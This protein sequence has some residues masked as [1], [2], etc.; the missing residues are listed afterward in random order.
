MSFTSNSEFDFQTR[1]QITNEVPLYDPYKGIHSA[2]KNSVWKWFIGWQDIIYDVSMATASDDE[3]PIKLVNGVESETYGPKSEITWNGDTSSYD[4]TYPEYRRMELNGNFIAEFDLLMHEYYRYLDTLYP[5][6][7]DQRKLLTETE[8]NDMILN[9]AEMIDYTPNIKFLTNVTSALDTSLTAD[10]LEAESAKLKIRDLLSNSFRRKFYGSK[11]GYRMYTGQIMNFCSVYPLGTYIPVQPATKEKVYSSTGLYKDNTGRFNYKLPSTTGGYRKINKLSPLLHRKF[12][13]IDWTGKSAKYTATTVDKNLFSGGALPCYDYNVFE[14]PNALDTASVVED[15]SVGSFFENTLDKKGTTYVTEKTEVAEKYTEFKYDGAAGLLTSSE[16]SGTNHVRSLA[17]SKRNAIRYAK[18][19]IMNSYD[20]IIAALSNDDAKS[21]ADGYPYQGSTKINYQNGS[22]NFLLNFFERLTTA[23]KNSIEHINYFIGNPFNTGT[24]L[25]KPSEA[26]LMYPE[27]DEVSFTYANGMATGITTG[28]AEKIIADKAVVKVGQFISTQKISETVSTDL[29]SVFEVMGLTKGIIS[30]NSDKFTTTVKDSLYGY[31]I[32]DPENDALYGMLVLLDDGNYV[33]LRG[34]VSISHSVNSSGYE[35]PTGGTFYI[36]SIPSTLD[37]SLLRVIYGT[38][39]TDLLEKKN[40]YENVLVA[41]DSSASDK[42]TAQANID[43]I[44]AAVAVLTENRSKVANLST[45]TLSDGTTYDYEGSHLYKGC[46]IAKFYKIEANYTL[47]S[48]YWHEMVTYRSGLITDINLGCVSIFPIIREGQLAYDS[49][50]QNLSCAENAQYTIQADGS[51]VKINLANANASVRTIAGTTGIFEVKPSIIPSTVSG[52]FSG[53]STGDNCSAYVAVKK[54]IEIETTVKDDEDTLDYLT[55]DSDVAKLAAQT[56]NVG[57][58]VSGTSIPSDTY[59]TE[60]DDEYIRISKEATRKGTFVLTYDVALNCSPVDTGENFNIYKENLQDSSLYDTINPFAHGIYPSSPYPNVSKAYID[61]LSDISLFEPFADTFFNVKKTLHK[62]QLNYDTLTHA[63]TGATITNVANNALVPATVKFEGDIF[64]EI[65]LDKLLSVANR[66]GTTPTLCNIE[67]LNY[68]EDAIDDISRGTDRVNVGAQ[69]NLMTDTTG[70][71]TLISGQ[72]YTDPNVKS[73]FATFNWAEDSVPAYAQIGQG[74]AGRRSWFKA[75]DDIVYPDL[76]GSTFYDDHIENLDTALNDLTTNGGVLSKRSVW[77]DKGASSGTS[78]TSELD[79]YSKVEDLLFE[80]P[81][82]EY[83]TQL[84]YTGHGDSTNAI[85]TIQ[86]AFYK[87][88][89]KNITALLSKSDSDALVLVSDS[90]EDLDILENISTSTVAK[91]TDATGFSSADNLADFTFVAEW[92][93]TL[94]NNSIVYPTVTDAVKKAYE[95]G[96]IP[97]YTIDKGSSFTDD[98]NVTTTFENSSIL[99]YGINQ[100]TKD[101]EW[102]NRVFKVGCGAFESAFVGLGATAYR[103]KITLNNISIKMGDIWYAVSSD[104]TIASFTDLQNAFITTYEEISSKTALATGNALRMNHLYLIYC[105][106]PK[107]TM[108]EDLQLF[109]SG[110]VVGMYFDTASKK[111][112]LFGVNTDTRFASTI[113]LLVPDNMDTTEFREVIGRLSSSVNYPYTVP[114]IIDKTTSSFTLPRN[115]I[116]EGSANFKF[117]VDP[118]FISIGNR[119]TE[120]DGV[121]TKGTDEVHFDITASAIFY[122]SDLDEFY[123]KSYEYT[124]NSLTEKWEKA[125]DTQEMFAIKFADQE[126]YKNL[127]YMY[128]TYQLKKSQISGSSDIVLTPVLTLIDGLKFKAGI[129]STDDKILSVAPVKMRSFYAS[130]YENIAFNSHGE[131]TGALRSITEDGKT[132]V[133]S[134]TPSSSTGGTAANKIALASAISKIYPMNEISDGVYEVVSDSTVALKDTAFEA[135]TIVSITAG[136]Q[137][138]G[139]TAS[140]EN[141]TL[142]NK[143]FRNA[144]VFSATVDR[145]TPNALIP[146]GDDSYFIAAASKLSLRDTVLSALSLTMSDSTKRTITM[147]D[148]NGSALSIKP[149]KVRYYNNALVAVCNNGIIYYNSNI[150]LLETKDTVNLSQYNVALKGTAD[151]EDAYFDSSD[152]TWYVVFAYTDS[153]YEGIRAIFKTSDFLVWQEAFMTTEA[154]LGTYTLPDGVETDDYAPYPYI[155][156]T[157]DSNAMAFAANKDGTA[158]FAIGDTLFVKAKTEKNNETA[159]TEEKYWKKGAIPK[160]LDTTKVSLKSLGDETVIYS[161]ASNLYTATIAKLASNIASVGTSDARYT[162]W[163]AMKANWPA[164]VAFVAGQ[165]VYTIKNGA[166]TL[167]TAAMNPTNI[168]GL[169]GT[170]CGNITPNVNTNYTATA[171]SD[172][173]YNYFD[174]YCDYMADYLMYFC[175]SNFSHDVLTDSIKKV[176]FL[177]GGIMFQLTN[178]DFISIQENKLCSKAKIEDANNWNSSVFSTDVSF[179]SKA[180]STETLNTYF[181]LS[182]AIS[183]ISLGDTV[184]KMA[185]SFKIN[186]IETN[187]SGMIVLGGYFYTKAEITA[188]VA[189]TSETTFSYKYNGTTHTP[190][191]LVSLDNGATFNVASLD[192]AIANEKVSTIEFDGTDWKAYLV[193]ET[194]GVYPSVF[195]PNVDTD[196]SML[197]WVL[198]AESDVVVA[199]REI[200]ETANGKIATLSGSSTI[201]SY[202]PVAL[203]VSSG[204]YVTGASGTK[205]TL[206]DNIVDKGTGLVNVLFS[207]RTAKQISKPEDFIDSASVDLFVDDTYQFKVTTIYETG[208]K[209]D[210]DRAFL[211]RET[212]PTKLLPSYEGGYPSIREDS[213]RDFYKYD[214]SVDSDGNATYSAKNLTNSSG[215]NVLLCD[216]NGNIVVDP[217]ATIS[218]MRLYDI[219]K[220]GLDFSYVENAAKEPAYNT[221]AEAQTAGAFALDATLTAVLKL[222]TLSISSLCK[223]TTSPN[224][225]VYSEATLFETFKTYLYPYSAVDACATEIATREGITIDSSTKATRFISKT[226][227]SID[228]V[229]DA[230]NK[231]YPFMRDVLINT[232]M[233][234]PYFYND[235]PKKITA[236]LLVYDAKDSSIVSEPSGLSGM[237][238]HD[239][240]YGGYNTNTDSNWQESLPWEVDSAAFEGSILHN[241]LGSK[242]FLCT[243]LGKK[244]LSKKGVNEVSIGNSLTIEQADMYATKQ[245]ISLTHD[246][247]SDAIN[248]YNLADNKATLLSSNSYSMIS[249]DS[250][251]IAT[252]DSL[253]RGAGTLSMIHDNATVDPSEVIFAVKNADEAGITID[254]KG[255]FTLSSIT[256]SKH[257]VVLSATYKKIEYT[258]SVVYEVYEPISDALATSYG[259]IEKKL[260]VF[261]YSS[262]GELIDNGSLTITMTIKADLTISKG[263]ISVTN[264]TLSGFEKVDT[265]TYEVTI[266]MPDTYVG[267]ATIVL[268]SEYNVKDTLILYAVKKDALTVSNERDSIFVVGNNG[269]DLAKTKVGVYAGT[270]NYELTDSNF[271]IDNA[272]FSYTNGTLSIKNVVAGVN[273]LIVF[274]KADSDVPATSF[275]LKV[276]TVSVIPS[277]LIADRNVFDSDISALK[278]TPE[279]SH[280]TGVKAELYGAY[281]YVYVRKPKYGNY[282][283]LLYNLGNIIEDGDYTDI[284]SS[285]INVSSIASDYSYIAFSDKVPY[286]TTSENIN[287][288]K[289]HVIKIRVLTRSSIV[290][291]PSEMEDSTLKYHLELSEIDTYVPDRV[292]FPANGFPAPPVVIGNTLF[293]S[294]SSYMYTKNSYA[295]NNGKYIYMCDVDGDYTKYTLV[296]GALVEAKLDPSADFTATKDLRFNPRTP[297]YTSCKEWYKSEYYIESAEQNPYWQI[298]EFKD[299]FDTNT[300]RFD[301]IVSVYAYKKASSSMILSEVDSGDRYL[302]VAQGSAYAIWEDSIAIQRY[303][304]FIDHKNGTLQ[305]ILT[306]PD[307][308]YKT[309]DF[310]MKYGIYAIN[311]LK[312]SEVFKTGGTVAIN[313]IMSFSYTVNTK[314]NFAN[315][316]DKESAIVQVSEVGVFNKDHTLIAYA[317]FPPIEYNSDTQHVAFNLFIKNG[318]CTEVT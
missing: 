145:E 47:R 129:L 188:M 120:L 44:I 79:E 170:Y 148:A 253:A 257:T 286:S 155:P 37:D 240:G 133:M 39:Y 121:Y 8:F 22:S 84:K 193:N 113:P 304:P 182:G 174:N 2:L 1:V 166:V 245:T 241:D 317:T 279:S 50:F 35:Y 291:T 264:C 25:M 244:I 303:T 5:T 53:V 242:V 313:S 108:Y 6:H 208:S 153:T 294:D 139:T 190:A 112:K 204:T 38:S 33:F 58:I 41:V 34:K 282:K 228:Y 314:C 135:P 55:F 122:N 59:I 290:L 30:F 70:Y 220:H 318:S 16:V 124:Y 20:S 49:S 309:S 273:S 29:Y 186:S 143:Y 274:V 43:S 205:I 132:L 196:S 149:N 207:F 52:K 105:V 77:R 211:Y 192:T 146:Y 267:N 212:L 85:T 103:G 167:I 214:E 278:V 249:A 106:D 281:G 138:S 247:D 261:D 239:N 31:S 54:S 256:K 83:D 159:L 198:T 32:P 100:S 254:A 98:K 201:V 63:V 24:L 315:K 92:E 194:G 236:P 78:D 64:A 21:L 165:K 76:Y 144:L 226:I 15:I 110:R 287:D 75:I 151:V 141:A 169:T 17:V 224:A 213:S 271:T 10:E 187:G 217:D 80:V 158:I 195:V 14:F 210:A 19:Y 316:L 183:A 23:T 299:V 40:Y 86:L 302:N 91:I 177:N 9:A 154:A 200:Q 229:Y 235:E 48:L 114:R 178:D 283:E 56:L 250:N 95:S 258:T 233:N 45:G 102:T 277:H 107:E 173:T 94:V 181:M 310:F 230:V 191:I 51:A 26:L 197:T 82:G 117:I 96:S 109:Y 221:L 296:N 209:Y 199:G 150:P 74:G 168:A 216:N 116:A 152:S 176:H 163:S 13:L 305:F 81:L 301:Q 156:T 219:V 60:V 265:T 248:I 12:R 118:E 260:H 232:T 164:P 269:Y 300:K 101:V 246:G 206:S 93:P 140:A 288:G 312:G 69:L 88:E 90:F 111:L 255:V 306:Q 185:K 293:N 237:F 65:A 189:T 259:Y 280:G 307:A 251:F 99:T 175:G 11:L 270:R 7:P 298:L 137:L 160:S 275:A 263:E 134:E 131:L 284:E 97:Y 285:S 128:G 268:E 223:S 126:Y 289:A 295:N 243:N 130:G 203:G 72:N 222:A 62:D 123:V 266:A 3:K 297:I 4:T 272:T 66:A 227:N 162:T 119:I 147:L 125:S 234:I 136:T 171:D 42:L 252:T 46:Q 127:H 276:N 71:Y 262:E 142:D 238:F 215:A 27:T 28:D 231:N 104:N 36:T 161:M 61:G 180:S 57:D 184:E 202:S 68:L 308:K 225:I 73:F 87:E 292:Y 89:F 172:G 218:I 311:V 115:C 179:S 67:W 18:T 157:V